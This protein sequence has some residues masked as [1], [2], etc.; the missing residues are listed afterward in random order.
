MGRV[1]HVRTVKRVSMEEIEAMPPLIT[2]AQGAA[3][4]GVTPLL[5][6]KKCKDG[7]FPAVKCGREWRINKAKF[8]AAVGLA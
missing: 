4:V 5:I 7:T 1:C 2:T 8:L 6:A 3:I